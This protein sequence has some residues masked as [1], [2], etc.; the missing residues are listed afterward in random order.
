MSP[1]APVSWRNSNSLGQRITIEKDMGPV[2]EDHTRQ[3]VGVVG[4]VRAIALGREP[5]AMMYVPIGQVT[6][7]MT[8]LLNRNLRLVGRFAQ[9]QIPPRLALPSRES[10]VRPVAGYP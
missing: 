3:I 7:E 5:D 2:F 4:G 6:E 1:T 8:G 10:S 9:K